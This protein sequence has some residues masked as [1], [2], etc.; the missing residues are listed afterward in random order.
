MLWFV[1]T[2]NRDNDF[3]DWDAC[4][5][6]NF[7]LVLADSPEQ[8]KEMMED[9]FTQIIDVSTNVSEGVIQQY[10]GMAMLCTP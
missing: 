3:D 10:G 2:L 6:T 5:Y 7:W 9:D 8:V 1:T 4:G